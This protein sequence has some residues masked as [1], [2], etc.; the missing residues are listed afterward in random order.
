MGKPKLDPRIHRVGS[1]AFSAAGLQHA[2]DAAL[3]LGTLERELAQANVVH[4]LDT[5]APRVD[6]RL[7]D[8]AG[9]GRVHEEQGQRQALIDMLG[10]LSISVDDLLRPDFVGVLEVFEIVVV[11]ERRR[12][13]DAA[14]LALFANLDL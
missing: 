2:A 8:V 10:C 14:E 9:C 4:R 11:E 1:I 7:V 3:D 12:V 6:L 5:F 13:V